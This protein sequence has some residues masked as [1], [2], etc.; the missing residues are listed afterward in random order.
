MDNAT[1]YKTFSN[2]LRDKL[3]SENIISL[4]DIVDIK[5]SD[6]NPY[7]YIINVKNKNQKFI[8]KK[9]KDKEYSYFITEY[10]QKIN[11]DIGTM[12]FPLTLIPPFSIAEHTYVICTYLEGKALTTLIPT[13][14]NNDLQQIALK[15]EENLKYIHSIT[16]NSYCEGES[17]KSKS[18]SEILIRKINHQLR[19]KLVQNYL[20]DKNIDK[21]FAWVSGTLSRESYSKPVL[22]H[23]D[24]NPGNIILSPSGDVHII[25]FELARFGE[26]EYEWVNLLS[27]TLHYYDMRYKQ[28]I[29][30][31]LLEKKF[32]LLDEALKKDKYKIYLLYHFLNMYIY[33]SKYGKKCPKE[34]LELVDLILKELAV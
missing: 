15:L 2:S 16:S 12:K 7:H 5:V 13:L 25:D 22:L 8:V 33:C 1:N 4:A 14:S 6:I 10:L 19:D 23:M 9:I 18:F 20:K 34:I 11:Q 24:I 21:L 17:F 28:C 29:L 32:M 31:P 3:I 26:V 30:Y 27:K